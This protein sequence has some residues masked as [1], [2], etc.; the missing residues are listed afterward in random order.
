KHPAAGNQ[1][2]QVLARPDDDLADPDLSSALHHF[3]QQRITL[4]GLFQRLQIVRFIVIDRTNLPAVD[5]IHDFYRLGGFDVGALKVFIGD[6]NE[7]PFLVFITLDDLIPWNFFS[8]L[9]VYALIMYRSEPLAVK[10]F[11]TELIPLVL[12]S[13]EGDRNVHESKIN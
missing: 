7:F 11:E 3:A 10:K 9:L 4:A 1:C 13:M 12:R 5:E 6:R 2:R 8:G